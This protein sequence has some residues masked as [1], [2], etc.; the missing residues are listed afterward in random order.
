MK[1]P[2]ISSKMSAKPEA[3]S[4]PP[5]PGTGPT[6]ALLERGVA[7]LVVGGALLVVLEDVV[8]LVDLLELLLRGLVARVAVRVMLHG[9]LAER[10]LD[11]V[12]G[13]A[14][15]NSKHV[16]K[17]ALRHLVSFQS[18]CAPETTRGRPGA[19]SLQA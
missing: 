6:A 13:G 9:E 1:S 8:G 10:L 4:N 16:I 12:A 7:E 5:A 2:N 3:N 17:I 19:L 11:V 15:R 18:H 14:P